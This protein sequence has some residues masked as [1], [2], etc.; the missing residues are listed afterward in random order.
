MSIPSTL[1]I[2]AVKEQVSDRRPR[3][4]SG[5]FLPPHSQPCEILRR[6]SHPCE[7]LL[8][9]SYRQ[10]ILDHASRGPPPTRLTAGPQLEI[11]ALKPARNQRVTISI[12]A[13]FIAT[14]LFCMC[15]GAGTAAARSLEAQIASN[16]TGAADSHACCKQ[17]GEKA[18]SHH[19]PACQHCTSSQLSVPDAVK[20]DAPVM[21]ASPAFLTPAGAMSLAIAS[22]TLAWQSCRDTHG[23]PP[24][25]ARSCVLL[26]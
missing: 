3:S 18:R 13:V 14:H 5:A 19:L 8:G 21:S 6:R 10:E 24:A 20:L 4:I 25:L 1:S 7:T 15:G 17:H 11:F 2:R 12:I 16:A 23:P 26:L 9:R 22:T